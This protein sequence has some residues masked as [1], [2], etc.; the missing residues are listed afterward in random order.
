MDRAPSHITGE[1]AWLRIMQQ[2]FGVVFMLKIVNSGNDIRIV[3]VGDP[4]FKFAF[5]YH[6]EKVLD[7]NIP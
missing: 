5:L 4:K 1:G 2:N 6:R 3:N 7:G